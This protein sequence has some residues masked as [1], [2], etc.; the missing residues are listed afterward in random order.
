MWSKDAGIFSLA[1]RREFEKEKH[2]ARHRVLARL[3]KVLA[4]LAGERRLVE[5]QSALT[6]AEREAA[7][8][9]EKGRSAHPA[10]SCLVETL[11][12]QLERLRDEDAPALASAAKGVA[13]A[14]EGALGAGIET[15]RAPA[16]PD[17]SVKPNGK[18]RSPWG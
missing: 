6:R 15:A 16:R 9:A 8:R 14:I 11:R 3:K 13:D 4:H 17:A 5:A 18:A 10:A 12:R 1:R 2:H 7:L